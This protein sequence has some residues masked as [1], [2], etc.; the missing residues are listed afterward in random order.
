MKKRYSSKEIHTKNENPFYTYF[1]S[2]DC[3]VYTV[4]V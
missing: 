1:I 3:T 4:Y 2:I